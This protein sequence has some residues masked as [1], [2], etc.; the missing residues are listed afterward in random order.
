MIKKTKKAVQVTSE[1]FYTPL[2]DF[3][4]RDRQKKNRDVYIIGIQG[5]QGIGKTFFANL[6]KNVLERRGYR[7]ETIS[8]DDYYKPH[9]E[10]LEISRKY[11]GNP[12]YEIS[13]GMPGTHNHELLFET[14][15]KARDAKNFHIPKFDKSLISGRGDV[16]KGN[17]KVN[18][19]LHFLI[20]EGWCINMPSGAQEF[21]SS[22]KNNRYANQIFESL[23]PEREHFKVVLEFVE[24]YQKI[25]HFLDNK[26]FIFGKNMS[27]T[28]SWRKDQEEELIRLKGRGMSSEEVDQFIKPFIPFNFF[29]YDKVVGN[30]NEYCLI[31]VDRNRWPKKVKIPLEESTS[32][33]TS[34]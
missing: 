17:K 20:L 7:V 3:Y 33:Y 13:R 5:P 34:K 14:I 8:I 19:K 11:S 25:W 4:I 22:I 27:W 12:F 21:L 24:K 15:K 16:A 23:D 2:I 1:S 29:I 18:T 6:T 31:E 26:T 28:T 32:I 30:N 9:S 10:R